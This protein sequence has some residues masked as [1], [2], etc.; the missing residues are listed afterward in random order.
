MS[1]IDL[2]GS[3]RVGRALSASRNGAQRSESNNINRSLL[4]LGRCIKALVNRAKHSKGKVYSIPFRES[5]LTWYLRE[6]L[7]GNAR[8]TMLATLNPVFASIQETLST[9]R[10]A[11]TAKHIRTVARVNEDPIQRLIR[12]QVIVHANMCRVGEMTPG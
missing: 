12:Q 3:E 1:L 2:A 9:L 4:V 5:V 11:S 8:T 6:S 10:Y 7:D